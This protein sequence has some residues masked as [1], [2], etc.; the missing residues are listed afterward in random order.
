MIRF[1]MSILLLGG[2][3]LSAQADLQ[4]RLL[5][6]VQ[7]APLSS[8]DRRQLQTLILEVVPSQTPEINTANEEQIHDDF[9]AIFEWNPEWDSMYR[10]LL[11]VVL[12]KSAEIEG[13]IASGLPIFRERLQLA[14]QPDIIASAGDPERFDERMAQFFQAWRDWAKDGPLADNPEAMEFLV[15]DL[16]PHEDFYRTY[17]GSTLF[18]EMHPRPM[19]WQAELFDLPIPEHWQNLPMSRNKAMIAEQKLKSLRQN[20]KLQVVSS[21]PSRSSKLVHRF[22]VHQIDEILGPSHF[23]ASSEIFDPNRM[24]EVGVAA[25]EK[26]REARERRQ[27][28]QW[29]SQVKVQPSDAQNGEDRKP[30]PDPISFEELLFLT[31]MTNEV[32]TWVVPDLPPNRA[33]P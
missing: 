20:L 14:M 22:I 24:Q 16:K 17:A 1:L 26:L 11:F 10:P 25:R 19:F 2:F 6:V 33:D 9:Q 18:P 13:G 12:A 8:D 27:R 3:S 21:D 31:G 29:E 30:L 7:D 4:G 32:D 5:N 28:E 15:R 23:G